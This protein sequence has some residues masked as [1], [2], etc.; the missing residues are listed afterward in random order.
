MN[1]N[2]FAHSEIIW[3]HLVT[4]L[5]VWSCHVMFLQCNS[6]DNLVIVSVRGIK[7]ILT[8]SVLSPVNTK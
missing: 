3:L 8:Q 2:T 5:P 1:I 7:S 4:Y 6:A